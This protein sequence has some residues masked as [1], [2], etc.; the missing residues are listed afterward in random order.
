MHYLL[1]YELSDGR[2]ARL[3]NHDLLQA[4]KSGIYPRKSTEV[5]MYD[6][7][8]ECTY[9]EFYVDILRDQENGKLYFVIDDEKKYISDFEFYGS[10]FR[11]LGLLIWFFRFFLWY[12]SINPDF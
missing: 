10:F 7:N 5:T 9:V 8:G 12:N 6:A 1:S 2:H 11:H 3:F 4:D